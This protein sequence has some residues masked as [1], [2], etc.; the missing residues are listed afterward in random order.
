M[1]NSNFKKEI[2]E[3]EKNNFSPKWYIYHYLHMAESNF[4][5][6]LKWDLVKSK[7]YFYVLRPILACMWVE[8]NWTPPSI[9]FDILLENFKDISLELKKEILSLLERKK[10]W[11]ELDWEPKIQ[12]LNDFLEEKIKYFQEESKKYRVNKVETE[13]L[14]IFFRRYVK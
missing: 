11:D 2:L 6:Y 10:N 8:K 9:E 7:K 1:E 12:I 4:R 14:N 5:E 3:L 13:V